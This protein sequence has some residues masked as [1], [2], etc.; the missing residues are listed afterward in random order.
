EYY[1]HWITL[2][3]INKYLD[4]KSVIFFLVGCHQIP[5][6]YQTPPRIIALINNVTEMVCA[7][8]REQLSHL[9]I[10]WFRRSKE[11][12]EFQH[13]LFSSA[14]H[15]QFHSSDIDKERYSVSKESFR[16]S[17]TLKIS[18]LQPLDAGIYYCAVFQS[19]ELLIGNGTELSVGKY[20]FRPADPCQDLRGLGTGRHQPRCCCSTNTGTY[21]L[22]TFLIAFS[23]S[24]HMSKVR[25]A[26]ALE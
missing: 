6:L 11:S 8:K 26:W 15:K 21:I 13:I 25:K 5:T 16:N 2:V 9:G 22:L 12:Q 1:S 20:C 3:Y 10:Y 19:P 7:M 4:H 14:L 24:I 23:E 18:R 17:Y